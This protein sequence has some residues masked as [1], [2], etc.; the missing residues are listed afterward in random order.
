MVINVADFMIDISVE[1]EH[2]AVFELS[3]SDVVKILEKGVKEASFKQEGEKIVA[4][5]KTVNE[6]SVNKLYQVKEKIKATMIAG[7][8][9]I[10]QVLPVKRRDEFLIITA[11]T[12]LARVLELDFVDP[13]RT[14]SNDINEVAAVLGI[15]AARKAIMVETLKVTEAQGI[16]IDIRHIML[17]AD[18]M[19]ASGE[20]KGISRYGVIIKKASVLARA[21]FETPMKHLIYAAL[22]GEVDHLTSV[23]ENVMLNQPVPIG[24]GLP[25]LRAKK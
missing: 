5:L 11:G 17:V 6:K 3:R 2:L 15:E 24:T 14:N 10:E 16:D 4:K 9:G 25:E 8:K 23:V 22:T 19:C 1:S 13:S 18:T 21:S 20:V 12:N 7:I